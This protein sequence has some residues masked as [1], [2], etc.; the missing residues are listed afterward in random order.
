MNLHYIENHT[1]APHDFSC[2]NGKVC[3]SMEWRC[4]KDDD[5]GDMSDET[6]CDPGVY[7]T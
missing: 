1:C 7:V 6:G 3:I 2:K 5:C 4:D